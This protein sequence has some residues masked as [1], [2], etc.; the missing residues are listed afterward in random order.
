MVADV[1]P[2]A[3]PVRRTPAPSSGPGAVEKQE[4]TIG[5]RALTD[6]IG[7]PAAEQLDPIASDR[8]QPSLDRLI[9][10]PAYEAVSA[11]PRPRRRLRGRPIDSPQ[12]RGRKRATGK[13]RLKEPIEAL[14]QRARLTEVRPARRAL[15]RAEPR[16][17]QPTREVARL[18]QLLDGAQ[19]TPEER[20]AEIEAGTP[21]AE[22]EPVAIRG[23]RKQKPY[24][25]FHVITLTHYRAS[26]RRPVAMIACG[27]IG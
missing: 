11:Q 16:L 19:V 14:T 2:V 1:L 3:T 12:A 25:W 24:L 5:G 10:Q 9:G 4:G 17:E 20:R 18:E 26:R 27:R 8:R 21:A 13:S 6:A 22:A 23:A 7:K 15:G